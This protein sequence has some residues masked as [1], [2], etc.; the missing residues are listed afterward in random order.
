MPQTCVVGVYAYAV[1]VNAYAVGIYAYARDV[2]RR[3]FMSNPAYAVGI[4]CSRCIRVCSRYIRVFRRC[5]CVCRRCI[6]VCSR[7]IGV[8]SNLGIYAMPGT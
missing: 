3:Q 4:V 5:I 7:C 1:L 8:C 2:E 6:R